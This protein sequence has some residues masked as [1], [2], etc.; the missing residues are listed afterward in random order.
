MKLD[1]LI[2]DGTV[3]NLNEYF[4]KGYF[5]IEE[6]F[7]DLF[8]I[9]RCRRF[10]DCCDGLA[11]KKYHLILV[12]KYLPQEKSPVSTGYEVSRYLH[13]FRDYQLNR[14]TPIIGVDKNWEEGYGDSQEMSGY[15]QLTDDA[16]ENKKNLIQ[17]IKEVLINVSTAP[18]QT[19][20]KVKH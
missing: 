18:T 20:S 1:L 8:N 10:E 4:D 16:E 19:F 2:I 7:L 6:A 17:K 9:T 15:V 14:H 13:T 5:G 12:G 3:G 11:S